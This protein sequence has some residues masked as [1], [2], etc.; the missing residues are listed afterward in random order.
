MVLA[1]ALRLSLQ[2]R[3]GWG[4]GAREPC[5]LPHG[6]AGTAALVWDMELP[7]EASILPLCLVAQPFPKH[8]AVAGNKRRQPAA[9]QPSRPGSGVERLT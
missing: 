1:N 2:V 5:A 9:I 6:L 8:Q 7:L 3:L 4:G